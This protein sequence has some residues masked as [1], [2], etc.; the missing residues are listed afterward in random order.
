MLRSWQP[1]AKTDARWWSHVATSSS[2]VMNRSNGQFHYMGKQFSP[3]EVKKGIC[4]CYR[5]CCIVLCHSCGHTV[6]GRLRLEC[7]EHPST[8]FLMDIYQCPK[9]KAFIHM[10]EETPFTA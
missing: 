8:I 7:S 2:R 10:M 5:P 1:S 4:I 9:C 6:S 3:H